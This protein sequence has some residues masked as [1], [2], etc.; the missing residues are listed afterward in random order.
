[1]GFQI[2]FTIAGK[3]HCIPIPVL[4]DENIVP[5]PQNFP[6][7]ELVSTILTI[8]PHL[9]DSELRKNLTTVAERYVNSVKAAL[10]QGV[11]LQ[12]TAV[13]A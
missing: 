3:K 13:K 10:P 6:E 4:V 2:C 7:L 9:K 5:I 8:A 11:E 1:V 12:E